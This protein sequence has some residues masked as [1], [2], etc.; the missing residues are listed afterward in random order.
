VDPPLEPQDGRLRNL[1]PNTQDEPD[2]AKK[3]P[4]SY[5]PA[6]WLDAYRQMSG[7]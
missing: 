1:R 3:L 2:N 7:K 4:L 5:F 6:E